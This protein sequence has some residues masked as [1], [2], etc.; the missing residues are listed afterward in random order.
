MCLKETHKYVV[1]TNPV[2]VYILNKKQIPE[3]NMNIRRLGMI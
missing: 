1:V 2:L 3:S